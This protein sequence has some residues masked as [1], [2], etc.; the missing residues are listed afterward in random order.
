MQST[1][2][3]YCC[4]MWEESQSLTRMPANGLLDLST[5]LINQK[6]QMLA[7]CIEKKRQLNENFQDCIGSEDQTDYST[8]EESVAGDETSNKQKPME[9]FFWES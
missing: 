3:S 1:S 5:C 6:L 8:E 7:I 2:L 4:A 9:N